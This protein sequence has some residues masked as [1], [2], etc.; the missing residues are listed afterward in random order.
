MRRTLGS[1]VIL[2]LCCLWAT[3]KD[4]PL[5]GI[6]LFQSDAGP[7]YAQVSNLLLNG[8]AEVY[9]CGGTESLDNNGYKKLPKVS[10]AA[11]TALERGSDGVL[12]MT[13][14]AGSTCVLPMNLKLE[15]KQTFA[16]Q[17]LADLAQLQGAL[18]SKSSNAPEGFP[19]PIKTGTRI[20][21]VPAADVELA[22]YLRA[23]RAQTIPLWQGY[24]KQFGAAP[25]TP[26]ARTALAT[27]FVRDAEA[28]LA[29]YRKSQGGST[30][31]FERLSK[32][33]A[34]TEEA[35]KASLS[36]AKAELVA[37]DVEQQVQAI[38]NL[39]VKEIDAFKKSLVEKTLGYERLKKA[40][41]HLDHAR[42]ADGTFPSLLKAE[43]DMNTQMQK[44]ERATAAGEAQVAA[45]KFDEGHAAIAG[46][47]QYAPELPRI[48]AIVDAAYKN[49]RSRGDEFLKESKLAEAISEFKRALEYRNDDE[50]STLL[51]KAEADLALFTNKESAQQAIEESNELAAKK[52]F[53]EAYEKLSTLPEAQKSYV[54]AEMEALQKP[55]VADLVARADAQTKVHLPIRGRA[56]E[57]AA[58][59]AFDFLTRASNLADDEGIR[60]KLDLVSD[61]VSDY[62]QKQAQRLLDKPRGVGVGLG[63]LLVKEGQR[64]KPD[65]E[66]L[67]DQISKYSPDYD[68][69]GKL[70]IAIY[71][72]DQTSRRDSLGFADQ[73]ADTVASGLETS[74]LTG[75]KTMTRKD[76][77]AME[78][79]VSTGVG[80]SNLQLVGDI[81]RHQV[82]KKMET[83]RLTSRYRAGH[84]EVK[85]PE[86]LEAGRAVDAAERELQR[87][88]DAF[89][90][91]LPRLKKKDAEAMARALDAQAAGIEQLR[92]KQAAIPESLLQTITEPYTYTKRTLN[93]VS[94]VEVALRLVDPA[95]ENSRLTDTVKVEI[96]RSVTI[97]ENVKP[98]DVDGVVAEGDPLDEI[99]LMAEAETEAKAVMVKKLI[100]WVRE[101]PPKILQEA[102][103]RSANNDFEA[104]AERYIVYLNSTAMKSTPERI[105][106]QTFLRANFNVTTVKVEP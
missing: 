54:A 73:L 8:K 3:A 68:T 17:E 1:L 83:Q 26:Q 95:V 88:K 18:V 30:P 86:W 2:I 36:F 102:R 96:P 47:V 22:E 105:E 57:D 55:Y 9:V 20:Q 79:D 91:T 67:K 23:E 33:K 76:R 62:Y 46:V 65:L 78:A 50:T 70:S 6:I 43:A 38:V 75:I 64:Y 24:L 25:H 39:A 94:A 13:T 60:I 63:W 61:A 21:F 77:N 59:Q 72:R 103:S 49:R 71:F 53:V 28:E 99:Q 27:L 98:E 12:R 92:R 58:R 45:R 14:A 32:A 74:G 66:A 104:A 29:A 35:R 34:Y 52:Q 85:N 51:K 5:T 97:L 48:A 15:K 16:V 90:A 84:R 41:T 81:V 69:K 37:A 19:V 44:V 82:D 11:V 31:E 89:N 80:L 10:L 93:Y 56:D 40:K 106:A 87:G 42:V 7:A 101:A 100:E 4:K